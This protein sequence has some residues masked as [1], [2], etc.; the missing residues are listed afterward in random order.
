MAKKH[1]HE[2]HTNH[3]AWAIPYG[4]LITLLLAFF[5][6][7]YAVS[8]VNEGKYRVLAD[9][10]S[11]ALGGPP[12]SLKP[13]QIGDKPEK[14][15]QSA[16]E[17]NTVRMKGFPQEGESIRPHVPGESLG[18]AGQRGMESLQRMANAVQEAMQGLIDQK[19]VL[20][21][22]TDQWLEI[23][24]NTDILFASGIAQVSKSAEPVLYDLAGILKQFPNLLRIEGHT[25]NVPISTLAFPSNWELSAARAASVVHLF[26]QAG[27][28]PAR[29]TVIGL[30][31]YHPVADNRSAEG[32]NRNRRVVVVVMGEGSEQRQV[33]RELSLEA[34]ASAQDTVVVP[35]GTLSAA[36]VQEASP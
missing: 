28:D 13:I 34:P 8:S 32:R 24:I 1:K 29:M 22:R 21:R 16:A 6:V 20:V 5:V 23:E 31:E 7:M 11:T 3:E 4:D 19:L 12:K 36:E 33:V 35:P 14:G 2:E 27:I 18:E 30:G 26:M 15:Q 9:S 17:F 25:D 10:L